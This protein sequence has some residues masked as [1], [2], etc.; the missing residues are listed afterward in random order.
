M[1]VRMCGWV[2]R[3]E[4]RREVPDF[5]VEIR[6]ELRLL[7]TNVAGK[8]LVNFNLLFK[9][10]NNGLRDRATPL[11]GI[12]YSFWWWQV[13][14]ESVSRFSDALTDRPGQSCRRA[15]T[16]SIRVARLAGR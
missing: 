9:L 1:G 14:W 11:I 12:E 4:S 8:L 2:S 3:K 10:D 7:K 6:R 16:G 15:E 5:A 13:R